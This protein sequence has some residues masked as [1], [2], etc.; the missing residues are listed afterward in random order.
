MP[1]SAPIDGF[2]LAYDR[3]G[4]GA[5]VVLLHGWPG[6]RQDHADLAPRLT[7]HADVIVP[8]PRGFGESDR[9]DDA[10]PIEY[11][12]AGQGASIVGLLDELGIETAVLAGYA[13]GSRAAQWVAANHPERVSALVIS[14]PVSGA[15]ERV[16][17]PEAMAE[18]WYQAFHQLDLC[19]ELID[20]DEPAV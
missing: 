8:D 3:G 15:G 18:F 13:V 7:P 20:G 4:S 6:K 12:A 11:G 1:L 5:P 2:R 14:P 10:E 19:D 9:R 16:L 17:T